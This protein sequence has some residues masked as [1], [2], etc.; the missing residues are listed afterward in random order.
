MQREA[1]VMCGEHL[2]LPGNSLVHLK[3]EAAHIPLLQPSL[4]VGLLSALQAVPSHVHRG[5]AVTYVCHPCIKWQQDR[6]W[7]LKQTSPLKKEKVI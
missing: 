1:A 4:L 2:L 6:G 3:A 5:R 7:F